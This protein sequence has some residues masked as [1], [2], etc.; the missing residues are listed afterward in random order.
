MATE[1]DNEQRL[2]DAGVIITPHL[3]PPYKA[4]VD[5]FTQDQVD[6]IIELKGRLDQA[7]LEFGWDPKSRQIPPSTC[8]IGF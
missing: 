8:R 7:D 1:G 2:R 4:F 5:G 3:E 6:L